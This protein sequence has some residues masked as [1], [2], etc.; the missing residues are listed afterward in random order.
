MPLQ[1]GSDAILRAMHRGY[2]RAQYLRVVGELRARDPQTEFTTDV[3]VGFPGETEEDHRQTLELIDEVGFLSCHVFR[4][5]PRPDTPAA[6]LESRVEGETARRR[7]AEVRRAAARTGHAARQRACD[8]VHEAVWDEIQADVAHG[9]T[10]A[11][12]EVVADPDPQM[13]VGWL[14]QVRAIAVEGDCL[15]ATLVRP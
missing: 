11:Y 13:R 1:S 15:R 12:H 6:Q 4:W 14:S 3:M 10:A 5:S 2:R 9:I 8:R 7:S